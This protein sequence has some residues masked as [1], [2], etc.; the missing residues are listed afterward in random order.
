MKIPCFFKP[1][2]YEA[3]Y[4]AAILESK[5]PNIRETIEFLIDTGASRTTILDKD[6]TRLGL[7]LSKLEKLSEGMLGIGGT[8][9]T[10]TIRNAKLTFRTQNGKS[11]TQKTSKKSTFSNT[12][13]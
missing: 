3:A 1:G 13:T 12:H 9:E 2:P 11:H 10:Y 7:D 4:V 6:T 5:T 8:V